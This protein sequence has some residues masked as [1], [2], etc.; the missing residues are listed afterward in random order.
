MTEN[1]S[2]RSRKSII[3]MELST[4]E[5][6]PRGEVLVLGKRCPI[7]PEAAKRMVD[8]VSPEQFE[9]IQPDDDL[10]DGILVRKYMFLRTDREKLIKTILEEAKPMMTEQCMIRIKCDIKISVRREI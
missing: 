4:F 5:I 10:V 3:D 9:L 8:S 7:G 1:K 6:P 2:G